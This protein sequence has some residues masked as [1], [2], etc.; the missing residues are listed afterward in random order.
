MRGETFASFPVGRDV[1]NVVLEDG[2]WRMV[3]A[4][5]PTDIRLRDLFN[6]T[7]VMMSMLVSLV[8]RQRKTRRLRKKSCD[9]SQGKQ[10][11]ICFSNVYS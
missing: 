9:I 10:A 6:S 1:Q 11:R 3:C 4:S 5:A 2:I 7:L 8:K